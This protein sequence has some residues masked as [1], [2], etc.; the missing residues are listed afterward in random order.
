[1]KFRLGLVVFS[2]VLSLLIGLTL[3]RGSGAVAAGPH[4]PVI[5]FSMDS[6][7]EERWQHDREMFTARVTELGADVS[8]QAANSDDVR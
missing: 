3:R 4:R 1:M 8:V 5:G 2:L 7:K 6:L